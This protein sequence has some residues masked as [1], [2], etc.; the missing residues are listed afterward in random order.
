VGS[1]QASHERVAEH[2]ALRLTD[3]ASL[4]SLVGIRPYHIHFPVQSLTKVYNGEEEISTLVPSH[5]IG[6][7]RP[8]PTSHSMLASC[9]RS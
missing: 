2:L 5:P 6:I 1:V 4:F 8:Y 7:W 9:F 3:A